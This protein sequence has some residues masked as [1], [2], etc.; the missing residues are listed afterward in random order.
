[1]KNVAGTSLIMIRFMEGENMPYIKKSDRGYFKPELD[2][3]CKILD[4]FEPD[5]IDGVLNYTISVIVARTL[6]KR[7]EKSGNWRYRFMADAI[8]VFE[9]AK[10]EFYRRIGSRQEDKAIIKNGDI[11]EYIDIDKDLK[12]RLI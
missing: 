6:N 9:C 2:S 11:E 8:K 12:E 5:E 1:M 3:L 10:L 7:N 4:Q